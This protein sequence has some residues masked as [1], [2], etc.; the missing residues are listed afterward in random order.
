MT[1]NQPRTTPK[2][3]TMKP[4]T[5]THTLTL[6]EA[7][8]ALDRALAQQVE[9]RAVAREASRRVKLALEALAVASRQSN[10]KEHSR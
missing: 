8:A 2:K 10:T 4:T 6:Q 3:E 5:P 1:T 7:A 9:A